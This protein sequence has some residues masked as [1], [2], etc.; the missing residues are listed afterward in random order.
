MDLEWSFSTPFDP[1]SETYK[2]VTPFTEPETRGLQAIMETV[3][4]IDLFIAFRGYGQSIVYPVLR[5]DIPPA[6]IHEHE[7]LAMVFV[8]AVSYTSRGHINYEIGQSGPLYGLTSEDL[9]P[10]AQN[11][12]IYTIDLP[13]KG[14][15]G[16]LHSES[17]I[18]STLMETTAGIMC[19]C[20]L[21]SKMLP[22]LPVFCLC[23]A[24]LVQG[25]AS[26]Q[27]W[28]VD[29]LKN[30]D[31]IRE[32]ENGGYFDIWGDNTTHA[33]ILVSSTC[34]STLVQQVLE[35]SEMRYWV[36]VE[37]VMSLVQQERIFM[38]TTKN[39]REH[40]MDWNVYH[41]TAD[42]EKFI[43][44]VKEMGGCFVQVLTAA[45]TE[46]GRQVLVIKVTDPFSD[47]P[48]TKI[49]IEAGIHAREWISPAVSLYILN[50]LITDDSWR[51]LLKRT[52]W[53]IVPVV[54]PDGYH[55]SFTSESARLWRKNRQTHLDRGCKG[56][57]LIRDMD[58]EWSF[59]T[60]FDPCSETY[61]GVTPFTEPE[62]RGLQAIMET[63]GGIDLFIAFRGYGQS[64]VYPVL[65]NDIPPANIHEHEVLAMVFVHAVSYTSRG[66]INYEI[67]QSGPLYGLTSEDLAPEAQ[68]RFIY[69]I[70]LPY[71]GRY[72]LLHSESNISSTLM[73]TTAGIMCMVRHITNT[74]H[75]TNP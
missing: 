71:K 31:V 72:G 19:M 1:C 16:L 7:V 13:Y 2:G 41:N 57:S 35:S 54:N 66:H 59:S 38:E 32:L 61:K 70:D 11:R 68:N 29:V 53:Y 14:R 36:E 22:V 26:I 69:T 15:Y 37:D 25:D 24:T 67:G 44:W 5:N 27:M 55:Y 73:E 62:T 74:G 23:L 56:V 4:G 47:E 75:C 51:D 50:L 52:E 43:N 49:W 12:F 17:N 64:I 42:V 28:S 30:N 46:E 6:N 34:R 39:N 48:K 9:A 65:R 18:S 58:L 21:Y 10:E 20:L 45:T 60:P 8:H 63:V 33:Q 3:G 40:P